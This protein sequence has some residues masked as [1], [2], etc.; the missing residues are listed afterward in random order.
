ML[1]RAETR[2]SL[3]SCSFAFNAVWTFL[4]CAWFNTGPLLG[5]LICH[6]HYPLSKLKEGLVRLGRCACH[7]QTVE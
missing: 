4:A 3:I 2:V 5:V 1:V 7:C 6:S